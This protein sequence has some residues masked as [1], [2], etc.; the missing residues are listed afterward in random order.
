MYI[1]AVNGA[2]LKFPTRSLCTTESEGVKLLPAKMKP[3]MSLVPKEKPA[4]GNEEIHVV[5]REILSNGNVRIYYS[6]GSYV[7]RFDGGYDKVNADGARQSYRFS[8]AAPAAFPVDPPDANEQIWLDEHRK[9]LLNIIQALVADPN[10]VQQFVDQVDTSDNIYESIS[11]RS[12][13]INLL[14]SP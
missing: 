11:I 10:L 2:T 12:K 1:E 4:T 8:T 14:V 6:D 13:T 3:K 7:E 5:K 9:N